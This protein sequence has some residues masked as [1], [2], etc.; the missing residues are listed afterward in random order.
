MAQNTSIMEKT[1]M[2]TKNIVRPSEKQGTSSC[3]KI[4]SPS[5]NTIPKHF[6]KQ[7][8]LLKL[9]LIFCWLMRPVTLPLK[10][11]ALRLLTTFSPICSR[12]KTIPIPLARDYDFAY[13]SPIHVT[14]EG[15]ASLINNF[16]ISTSC[17]V[18][19]I[20]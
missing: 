1:Q 8:R 12:T 19:G 15:I 13:M 18:D 10:M 5:L 2:L 17:G 16:K 9:L 6:G 11:N 4:F 14:V 7:L 20:N 3:H